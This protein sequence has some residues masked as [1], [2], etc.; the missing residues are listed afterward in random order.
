MKKVKIKRGLLNQAER[1]VPGSPALG[2]LQEDQ[3]HCWTQG[4]PTLCCQILSLKKKI[5]PIAVLS[6]ISMHLNRVWSLHPIN[7]MCGRL[8]HFIH[9]KAMNLKPTRPNKMVRE[10]QDGDNSHCGRSSTN[11]LPK[12]LKQANECLFPYL[13]RHNNMLPVKAQFRG[14][15]QVIHVDT[16]FH[17]DKSNKVCEMSLQKRLSSHFYSAHCF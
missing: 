5:P 15:Y 4:Q 8:L 14:K 13:L 10:Y 9:R 7:N 3:N 11:K 17:S 1:L 16:C 6:D 12:T 2:R